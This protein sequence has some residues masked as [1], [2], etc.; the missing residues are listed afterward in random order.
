M[1]VLKIADTL[2]LELSVAKLMD[3]LVAMLQLCTTLTVQ[4]R[5][6]TLSQILHIYFCP[7]F[8]FFL[9]LSNHGLIYL[10]V[11]TECI[12]VLTSTFHMWT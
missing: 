12:H 9:L 8:F 4:V 6:Q 1:K 10:N 3:V 7:F 11:R 2:S 5:L